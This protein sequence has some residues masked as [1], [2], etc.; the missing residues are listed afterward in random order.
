MLLDGVLELS[1]TSPRWKTEGIEERLDRAFRFFYPDAVNAGL[2]EATPASELGDLLELVEGAPELL[3]TVRA[4]FTTW[5]EPLASLVAC[6]SHLNVR[7]VRT[8]AHVV[9]TSALR[10]P[11]NTGFRVRTL[12]H[13]KG[14]EIAQGR[15]FARFRPYACQWRRWESNPRP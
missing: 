5:R 12:S 8:A 9:R 15:N 10:S 2:C 14:P 6:G 13:L 3:T 4:T 1:R 7:N 11:R